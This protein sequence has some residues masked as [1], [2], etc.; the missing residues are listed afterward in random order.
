MKSKLINLG[1]VSD[2]IGKNKFLSEIAVVI[3]DSINDN[4]S[5]EECE[6]GMTTIMSRNMRDNKE[7][8][9]K[10]VDATNEDEVDGLISLHNYEWGDTIFTDSVMTRLDFDKDICNLYVCDETA[11][12]EQIDNITD[13]FTKYNFDLTESDLEDMTQEELQTVLDESFLLFEKRFEL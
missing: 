6:K 10:C 3:N 11:T 5:L 13:K 4:L 2:K 9:L 12:Q 1:L 8:T 7:E